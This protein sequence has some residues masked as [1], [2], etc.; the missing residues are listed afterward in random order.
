MKVPFQRVWKRPA[1]PSPSAMR[2]RAA[3]ASATP[4]FGGGLVVG[5]AVVDHVGSSREKLRAAGL[6]LVTIEKSHHP[7]ARHVDADSTHAA[8]LKLSR[9]SVCEPTQSR[10]TVDV[11]RSSAKA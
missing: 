3:A 11:Q 4:C 8:A 5:G 7:S 6:Y 2:H 10:P 9:K 1:E